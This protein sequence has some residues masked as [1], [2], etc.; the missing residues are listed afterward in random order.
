MTKLLSSSIIYLQLMMVA[1]WIITGSRQV[2][3][4]IR[5]RRWNRGSN[6]RNWH[7][8]GRLKFIWLHDNKKPCSFNRLAVKN[9]Q[10]DYHDH[11]HLYNGGDIFLRK[12]VF[13]Y[14][15]VVWWVS[16]KPQ[17]IKNV[18][19][20]IWLINL[21]LFIHKKFPERSSTIILGYIKEFWNISSQ[22]TEVIVVNVRGELAFE[23]LPVRGTWRLSTGEPAMQLASQE[24]TWKW[25]MKVSSNGHCP[26]PDCLGLLNC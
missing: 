13:L 25:K 24:T 15:N 26:P 11:H 21:L 6:L 22:E 7:H 3:A 8:F 10:C 2:S 9:E 16:N 4:W 14:Q 19:M 17:E 12:H 1:A 5:H 23:L 18:W 20:N